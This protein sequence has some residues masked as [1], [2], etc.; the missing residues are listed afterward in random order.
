MHRRSHSF[1]GCR[2]ENCLRVKVRKVS[3][4]PE[5]SNFNPFNGHNMHDVNIFVERFW[6]I[7]L[8]STKVN[9]IEACL[10]IY[11]ASN[12]NLLSD[13]QNEIFAS[14]CIKYVYFIYYY[15]FF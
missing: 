5:I 8:Q 6:K 2:V 4:M 1:A 12:L 13:E 11:V 15:Y 9:S 10:L 3:R 14:K 7:G